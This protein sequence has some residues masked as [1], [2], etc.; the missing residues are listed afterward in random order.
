MTI[1]AIGFDADD[2]LWRH[3]EFYLRAE[4]RLSALLAPS[5]NGEALIG[6]LREIERRNL[7]L[8]GFGAKGFTLSMI[9]TAI[10][11]AGEG[12]PIALV[13]EILAAGRTL[14]L[15]PIEPL[16]HANDTLS[17]LATAYRLILITRGDLLD[18]ERK[19][20]LSGLEPFF[21]AI[22]IVS[23]KNAATYRRV[24][25]RHADGPRQ[26]MMVGNSL[27]SDVLPAL[28][29]GCW[30]VHVPQADAWVGEHAEPPADAPRFRAIANLSELP[31]LLSAL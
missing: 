14:L 18:Q 7:P 31:D 24:F 15:H 23:D 9:E 3:A 25:S 1:S 21:D 22:E 16:P 8:Y 2:T 11:V 6:R 26:A 13:T 5:G 10:A 29:A 27:R 20:A 12:A 17:K 30:G 28:E 4:D 19:L